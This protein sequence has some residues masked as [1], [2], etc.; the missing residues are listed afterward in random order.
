MEGPVKLVPSTWLFAQDMDCA[1]WSGLAPSLSESEARAGRHASDAITVV[2]STDPARIAAV[3]DC[4][5]DL[6]EQYRVFPVARMRAKV[7]SD[8]GRIEPGATIIQ[9]IAVGP[10]G[11]EAAVRVLGTQRSSSGEG[12][13]YAFEYAT[14]DG[15]PEQGIARFAVQQRG[16]DLCRVEFTIESWSAPGHWLSAA[17]APFTLWMQRRSTL[18]ALNAFRAAVLSAKNDTVPQGLPG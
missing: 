6:L 9:Q 10:M 12:P 17:V 13:S 5:V 3:F 11:F 1:R 4:A 18:Q 7:C 14:L 2:E 16:T 8:S 15:H